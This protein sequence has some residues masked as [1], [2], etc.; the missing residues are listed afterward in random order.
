MTASVG[1]C[2]FNLG[3]ASSDGSVCTLQSPESE[4]KL[5]ECY[6]L[7][8]TQVGGGSAGMPEG[9]RV[10]VLGYAGRRPQVPPGKPPA[11]QSYSLGCIWHIG[12]YAC[13]VHLTK[14]CWVCVAGTWTCVGGFTGLAG[15]V[16]GV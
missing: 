2:I 11:L 14:G 4:F 1:E 6:S 10:L 12:Q 7:G 13:V 16:N 9:K 15:Q 5:H 8:I 3:H